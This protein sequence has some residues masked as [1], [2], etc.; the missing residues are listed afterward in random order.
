VRQRAYRA[1]ALALEAAGARRRRRLERFLRVVR[2]RVA[3]WR[4]RSRARFLAITKATGEL[5]ARAIAPSAR[6]QTGRTGPARFLGLGP[7]A[8]TVGDAQHVSRVPS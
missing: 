7:V 1:P 2:A 8:R 5:A 3:R 6:S 4:S